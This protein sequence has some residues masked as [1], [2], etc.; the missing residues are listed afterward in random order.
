[1]NNKILKLF[2]D[3]INIESV[4]TDSSRH[5]EILKAVKFLE[6]EIKSLGFEVKTY[7]KNNCPPLIIGY[8][9][10]SPRSYKDGKTKTTKTIGI[11]AHYDVQPE[12]PVEKWSSPP[13]ELTKRNG[14]L[15]G[16]GVADDKGHIIQTL[17]AIRKLIEIKRLRN[18]I[19]LIFEGEEEI[20][21]QNF[22]ELINQAKK[23]LEKIDAF[24]I[25]DF[26]METSDQPEI[27]FGL[28]GL[29]GFEIEIQI[30]K[31]DL[32]SGVYGNQVYNPIQILSELFSKIK[33]SKTRKILIPHFYDRAKFKSKNN[34]W[35]STKIHPSFDISGITGGY[36]GP[37][38]KTIIPA[39][40]RAKFSFRLIENQTPDAIE[41]LVNDFIRKNLPEGVKYSLK[42]LGKL[43][44]FY[45]DIDNKYVKTTN[46]IF[47]NIFGKQSLFTRSGGS[48]GAVATLAKLFNKPLILTGFTLADC[49]IH[50]P[51]EN[52]DEEMFFKGIES[53][54][55]IFSL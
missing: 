18:N 26:G 5:P 11:Y 4:S 51:N 44:P 10:S 22:E 8:L 29:I 46:K 42:T 24:Y 9:P 30:G 13:F 1:M 2:S 35:L 15:F 49:D 6:K 17:V 52:I 48:I 7:Q 16:R 3:F 33:D 31:K 25:L 55:K 12:D 19:V 54:E 21:S 39:L 47:A 36:T 28:R 38:V 40:A 14:K 34:L 32:H 53:L 23:D 41:K 50:A 45:T 37:G 43:D 27:F 20:G